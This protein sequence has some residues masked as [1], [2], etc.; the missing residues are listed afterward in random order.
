MHSWSLNLGAVCAIHADLQHVNSIIYPERNK[1]E[2]VPGEEGENVSI[3]I[4]YKSQIILWKKHLE[5][6]K[7]SLGQLPLFFPFKLQLNCL[8]LFISNL[9]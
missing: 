4:G 8:Q 3:Y 7:W 1:S 9:A 6:P 2:I 5:T